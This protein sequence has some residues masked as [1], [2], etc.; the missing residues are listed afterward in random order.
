MVFQRHFRKIHRACHEIF[1]IIAL[2]DNELKL[3]TQI[4]QW[5][6]AYER[7]LIVLIRNTVIK[8]RQ[9]TVR[10][11]PDFSKFRFLRRFANTDGQILRS[12]N[13]K[14]AFRKGR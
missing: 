14:I 7:G 12:N 2:I 6:T 3:S 13:Y 4:Q 11:F 1:S 5:Q 9:R 10:I 8:F